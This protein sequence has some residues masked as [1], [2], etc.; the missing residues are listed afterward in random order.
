M[1]WADPEHRKLYMRAYYLKH[2]QKF[3]ASARAREKTLA[4][5]LGKRNYHLRKKYGI[6]DSQYLELLHKQDRACAICGAWTMDGRWG[7]LSVDHDHATGQVRG[8]L[9]FN[10]NKKL[11]ILEDIDFV[12]KARKYLAKHKRIAFKERQRRK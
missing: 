2:K 8:L 10:C 6:D 4:G 9:C 3:I 11:G 1:P 5:K 7:V 12:R